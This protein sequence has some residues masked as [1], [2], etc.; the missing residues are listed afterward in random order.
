MDEFIRSKMLPAYW[1]VVAL[2]RKDI[3]EI[4]P[5]AKEVISFGIPAFKV[6]HIIVHI[7]PTKTD[8]TL[9]FSHGANFEDKY[10]LLEGVGL[11][12]KYLKLKNVSEVNKE[13][14]AYYLKQALAFD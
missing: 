9:S 13:V 6:K 8:V 10:G 2:I 11:E 12:S 7:S 5:E 4:V 3:L 14:L 1:D